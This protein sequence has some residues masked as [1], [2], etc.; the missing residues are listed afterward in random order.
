MQIPLIIGTVLIWND[1][2]MHRHAMTWHDMTFT[3]LRFNNMCTSR[4]YKNYHQYMFI[5]TC[6]R[7]QM[8]FLPS[9]LICVNAVFWSYCEW[10]DFAYKLPIKQNVSYFKQQT[11]QPRLKHLFCENTTWF[12]QDLYEMWSFL[13]VYIKFLVISF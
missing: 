2:K 5:L 11:F 9:L 7:Y 10:L 3:I 8:L 13:F 4:T 6:F 12:K 1:L